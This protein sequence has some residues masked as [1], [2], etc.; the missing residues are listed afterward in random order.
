MR[1]HIITIALVA[2]TSLQALAYDFMEGELC[3]NVNPDGKSVS[4]TSRFPDAPSYNSEDLPSDLV[5]PN[6]VIHNDETYTVTT[7]GRSAFLGCSYLRSVTMPSSVSTIEDN[8]F[9]NCGSLAYISMPET[10]VSV[11]WNAFINTQW[12]NS[13]PT[14][15]VYVGRVAYKYKGTAPTGTR[16]DLREGTVMVSPYAF[17]SCGGVSQVVLPNTL[18]TIGQEAFHNCKALAS[19][20]FPQSLSTIGEKSFAYCSKLS[21]VEL[22]K[23]VLTIGNR[24]FEY[25]TGITKVVLDCTD[26]QIGNCLFQ[27]CDKLSSVVWNIQSYFISSISDSPFQDCPRVSSF[28]FGENVTMIPNYICYNMRNITSIVIPNTVISIGKESFN[29]CKGLTNVELGNSLQ[30]IGELAFSDCQNME[31]ITFGSSLSSIGSFAFMQCSKLGKITLPKSLQSVGYSAFYECAGI[32][33]VHIEDL[34]SW[35]GI[36]FENDEANPLY[37]GYY[38]YLNDANIVDLVIPDAV[39]TINDHAFCHCV[40]IKS[41]TFP[42]SLVT[43]GTNAFK[44]CSQ[45]RTV[46]WNARNF[47]NFTRNNSLYLN[48]PNITIIKFG[49]EVEK[50]P[51]YICCQLSKLTTIDFGESASAIGV[52]AFLQCDHLTEIKL[53]GSMT[54]IGENSFTFCTGLTT[55]TIPNSVKS[56]GNKAFTECSGLTS[57]TLGNGLKSIGYEAFYTCKRLT[58]VDSYSDPAEV[59]MGSNVFSSITKDGSLHVLPTHYEAYKTADQW[60]EFRVIIDDLKETEGVEIVRFNELDSSLPVEIYDLGGRRL[61]E[62]LNDIPAGTYIIRQGHKIAKIVK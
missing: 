2:I 6:N 41:V 59:A 3:Y 26:A 38:L 15:M 55:M 32:K 40:G 24:A 57:V 16:I 53:P 39:E 46:T 50:I 45:V 37:Y 61:Y 31:S 13:Q 23:T 8:A 21:T 49:N 1:R 19:I 28:V 12:F 44:S 56:I 34:A 18:E 25:C 54:S 10:I 29:K 52:S 22:P 48:M 17:Y 35:C 42:A 36:H 47:S 51:D 20:N 11:G 60:R 4:V 14:G 9:M 5:I 58:R 43:M 62:H 33:E 30:S 27:G 7:I